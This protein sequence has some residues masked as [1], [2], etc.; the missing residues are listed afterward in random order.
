MNI[1]STSCPFCDMD[2]ELIDY[3]FINCFFIGRISFISKRSLFTTPFSNTSLQKLDI[4]SD[5][6]EN[7]FPYDT[8]R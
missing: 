4:I 2:V 8:L 7:L 3:L 1:A 5:K 6:N